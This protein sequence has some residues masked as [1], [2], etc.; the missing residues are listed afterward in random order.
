ML[1]SKFL[2]IA[3]FALFSLEVFAQNSAVV[4]MQGAKMRMPLE[5]HKGESNLTLAGLTPG[6]TYAVTA[7]RAA[8]GQIAAFELAPTLQ[9]AQLATDVS[10]LNTGKNTL[11]FTATTDH[12]DFQVIARTVQSV[13]TLPMYL[14]VVCATCAIPAVHEPESLAESMANLQLTPNVSAESLISNT[15][16][17]GDCFAVSNITASGRTQSRGTFTNGGSNI[18]LDAGMVLSTGRVNIWTGPNVSESSDGGFSLQQNFDNDLSSLVDGDLHDLSKIEFDFTPTA[19]T[20][21]FD[22]VF[23]S[24]E[25]CEFVN[26][27]YNDVFGFFISGPGISGVQNLAVIP[28]TGGVPVTI[29]NVNHNLNSNYYVNNSLNFL[30]CETLTT[31]AFSECEL[32]GWTT[33]LTA[34][35]T[36]IPCST[37]HIKLAIADV[38]DNEYDSA[39]FLRA[40]SFNAGGTVSAAATYPNTQPNAV[41]NCAPGAIRFARAN[42]DVSQPLTV[43][44]AVSGA[45]TA[46]PGIDYAPMTSPVII[47]AGQADLLVPVNVFSDGLTEGQEKIVLLI[48]N[49]CQCQQEQVEYLIN[50]N[51]PFTVYVSQDTS[52]CGGKV[53]PLAAQTNGGLAPFTY[54]WNTADTS[55]NIL[56]SPTFSS[57]YTVTVTDACGGTATDEA[58]VEVI[59][60]I[61]ETQQDTLCAGG[62]IVIN[63]Q[64]YTQA[65]TVRD[66]SYEIFACGKIT[67]YEIFVLPPI[68]GSEPKPFCAGDSVKIGGQF[69][70]ESGT[71]VDTFS[72]ASGCDSIVTYT[73]VKKPLSYGAETIKL[74]PGESTDIGGQSYMAPDTVVLTLPSASDCDSIVTYTL[75]LLPQPTRTDTV[76]LCPGDSVVIGG[77]TITEPGTLLVY[78]PATTGCD[79]MVTYTFVLLPEPTRTVIKKFCPGESITLGGT[80]YTQPGTV[81][82]KVPAS[83]GCDTIVTYKLEYWIPA[84]SEV[85]L[86]CPNAVTVGVPSGVNAIAVNYNEP[87]ATS[88]CPC[89]GIEVTRT[90]GLA[91]GSAFPLGVTQV[92]YQAQDKCGHS[93]T[94]CF[95]VSVEEDDPCDIKVIGCMKYELLTITQDQYKNKTYR[96]R[97]TNNCDNELIYTAIQTPSG[98]VAM[99][100]ATN[101]VYT[102]PSGNEYLVRNPNFSPFYSVRFKAIN[103]GISN[104]ESDI[105]RYTL[106]AQADVLF[107]HIISKISIQ[108]YYEAHLNTFYCP[109]GTTPLG[110]RSDEKPSLLPEDLASI[111]LFPNPTDGV[112]NVDLAD[113][114]GEKVHLQVLNS[115][116]QRVL[117]QTVTASVE[118]Q[119]MDLPKG[120]ADGLYF[121]EIATDAGE[122]EVLKFVVSH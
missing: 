90:A 6:N 20:V 109:V 68:T 102:A 33:K 99:S 12:I 77:V 8:S 5:V 69:Y 107:I 50:D 89:P 25:Y 67:T 58:L 41:E 11:Q 103:G 66:T 91:S 110:E 111:L 7:V 108:Q 53:A 84:P 94:C 49:S 1:L 112:I 87:T 23:G 95:N 115:Q 19:N 48:D 114:A 54:S 2:L 104:G 74:C 117:L 36:V 100:P 30:A 24:E 14:S 32:D 62:S 16:I 72:T 82:I 40:N 52:I 28:G 56:V 113:W 47:P 93:Q 75:V 63:G 96:I 101:S 37:Y 60:V 57:L 106:P 44:F 65:G 86:A 42:G 13:T 81:V 46:T 15:L 4:Q 120:I 70:H 83:V 31:A 88:D 27:D 119:Q 105:L 97:V 61:Y 34:T 76:W 18:G 118:P 35:A 51:E 45:S 116:G 59:P 39:V 73:L 10:V 9:T 98:M 21:Q 3:F 22:F 121:L 55:A 92:C 79:T 80:T 71:V 26:S 64:V 85:S 78:Y 43:N 122:K 17:G 38:N 29:N